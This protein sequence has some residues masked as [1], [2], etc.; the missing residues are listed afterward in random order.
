MVTTGNP[1]TFTFSDGLSHPELTAMPGSVL[2]DLAIQLLSLLPEVFNGLHQLVVVV[3]A[4]VCTDQNKIQQLQI[5]YRYIMTYQI[6]H[7][8]VYHA[9]FYG[10]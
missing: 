8:I 10:L 2:Q 6:F 3:P 1:H 7:V 9:Y 4:W 5:K